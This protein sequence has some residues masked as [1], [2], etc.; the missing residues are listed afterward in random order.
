MCLY[1]CWTI[2]IKE[3]FFKKRENINASDIIKIETDPKQGL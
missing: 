3:D 1:F 2:I